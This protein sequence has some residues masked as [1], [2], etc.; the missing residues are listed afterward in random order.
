VATP[1][2]V[3]RTLNEPHDAQHIQLMLER[4]LNPRQ[5]VLL[6]VGDLG[7][8]DEAIAKMTGVHEGSV[9][10]WRSKDPEV[11]DPRPPQAK[12]IERIRA[13]AWHFVQSQAIVDLR[14]VGAWFSQINPGLGDGIAMEAPADRP[15][16]EERFELLMR[17]AKE[18]TMPGAGMA[19]Q[20]GAQ[21]SSEV[22][23]GAQIAGTAPAGYGPPGYKKKR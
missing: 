3:A 17:L 8:T 2:D 18:F 16:D 12:A 11:G 19:V 22:K 10:R 4:A 15:M 7:F 13:I 5:V 6:L 1:E 14:G 20:G 9:R 23:G 21:P